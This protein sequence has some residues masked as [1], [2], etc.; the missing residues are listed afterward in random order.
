MVLFEIHQRFKDH[1]LN[2]LRVSCNVLSKSMLN[3]IAF[4][5][6]FFEPFSLICLTFGKIVLSNPISSYSKLISSWCLLLLMAI[7]VNWWSGANK[8]YTVCLTLC[9]SYLVSALK[10]LV[11]FLKLSLYE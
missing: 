2:E 10:C 4:R 5:L 11:H 8:W 7:E 3:S 9:Y 6:S 1:F